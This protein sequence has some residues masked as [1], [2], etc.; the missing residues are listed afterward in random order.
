M[1]PREEPEDLEQEV[2]F[3][4]APQDDAEESKDQEMEEEIE[5]G[6]IMKGG[7]SL[8]HANPAVSASDFCKH[9]S[10]IEIH[11]LDFL[12]YS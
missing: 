7:R 3:T 5:K 6:A 2:L 1:A 9:L 8:K 4:A 12:V 10:H 11:L